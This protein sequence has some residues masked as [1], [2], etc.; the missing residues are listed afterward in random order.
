[1]PLAR[2][3]AYEPPNRLLLS[4]DISPQW[5]IET[6]PDRTSEWEVR[7]TAET[8]SRTRV[9]IEHRNLERHGEGWEGVRFGIDGDRGWPLYL[10]RFQDLFAGKVT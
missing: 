2:V 3:L 8:N 7:F 4:W 10:R 9:E 6:N 5:Q 1:M